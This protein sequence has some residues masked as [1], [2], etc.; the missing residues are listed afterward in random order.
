[1][2]SASATR[3]AGT[4]NIGENITTETTFIRRKMMT[5]VT[6]CVALA[7]RLSTG[8]RCYT[9]DTLKYGDATYKSGYPQCSEQ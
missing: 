8:S 1:M 9:N 6:I 3:R 5:C 7:R 4:R 2:K